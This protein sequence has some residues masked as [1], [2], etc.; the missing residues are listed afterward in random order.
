MQDRFQGAQTKYFNSPLEK[1]GLGGFSVSVLF[2]P[3]F[4]AEAFIETRTAQ[5]YF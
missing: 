4:A 1:R 5:L 2:S 3:V